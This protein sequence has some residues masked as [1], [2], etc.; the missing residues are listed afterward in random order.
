[1]FYDFRAMATDSADWNFQS[2][3][4]MVRTAARWHISQGCSFGARVPKR[5]AHYA[6]MALIIQDSLAV[7]GL[8]PSG[9]KALLCA[10]PA[11][12]CIRFRRLKRR[13][14]GVSIREQKIRVRRVN[15]SLSRL[16]A[17]GPPFVFH[18]GDQRL[19]PVR[20]SDRDHVGPLA[21]L[22]L[23]H[24]LAARPAFIFDLSR[25]NPSCD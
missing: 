4:P 3:Y 24:A 8:I 2:T 17:R 9:P 11:R 5:I 13:I 20:S 21:H 1:M 7:S 19:P 6:T 10:K 25:R 23:V 18:I 12:L 15:L 16:L 14:H 22:G